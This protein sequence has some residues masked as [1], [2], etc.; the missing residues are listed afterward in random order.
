MTSPDY[1]PPVQLHVDRA[2]REHAL[3]TIKFLV[4]G[5][6]EEA[7]IKWLKS[8]GTD[9]ANVPKNI[10]FE[11]ENHLWNR[12]D[13]YK[14]TFGV[15]RKKLPLKDRVVEFWLIPKQDRA[16]LYWASAGSGLRRVLVPPKAQYKSSRVVCAHNAGVSIAPWRDL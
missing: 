1:K 16:R 14:Y 12:P 2:S 8:L 3:S 10:H 13:G 5:R 9:E 15:M 4:N 11:V 6:Y 7:G